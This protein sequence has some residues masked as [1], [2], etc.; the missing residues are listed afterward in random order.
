MEVLAISQG[1]LG[2]IGDYL[3]FSWTLE[4]ENVPQRDSSTVLEVFP[5]LYVVFEL[6][7]LLVDEDVDSMF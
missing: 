7:L 4:K 6:K 3:I 5:S 1:N 2:V